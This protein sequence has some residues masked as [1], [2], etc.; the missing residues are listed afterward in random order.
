MRLGRRSGPMS[1]RE[2]KEDYFRRCSNSGGKAPCQ[3]TGDLMTIDEAHVDHFPIAFKDLVERFLKQAGIV[4]NREILSAPA[5]RQT[6]TSF[7]CEKTAALF[8]HF[9]RDNANLIVVHKTVNLTRNANDHFLEP[10]I[11]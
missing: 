10:S 11:E 9:H 5:D 3:E 8:I 6:S 2:F 4:P 1:V 7:I